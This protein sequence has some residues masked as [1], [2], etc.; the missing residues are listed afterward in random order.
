MVPRI[1]VID[2]EPGYVWHDAK[3]GGG[4]PN[5]WGNR[6]GSSWEWLAARQQYYYHHY[7]IEQPDLN[8]R[9]PEVREEVFNVM[10]FWLRHG[11]TG[12]R[13]DGVSNL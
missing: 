9:N 5:N 8:W 12:F 7:S 2:I 1:E 10:R 4:P 6:N 3:P 11:A 13:L